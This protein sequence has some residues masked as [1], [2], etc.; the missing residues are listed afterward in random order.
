MSAVATTAELIAV[1]AATTGDHPA[2]TFEGRTVTYA[3]LDRRSNQLLA[4][5]RDAGCQ[6]GDHVAL[7]MENHPHMAEVCWAAYRGG[8]HRT[9]ISP[10][11]LGQHAPRLD[12]LIK[13]AGALG[14][15]PCELIPDLRWTPPARGPAGGNFRQA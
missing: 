12:T 5:L 13:L 11:E 15:E 4:L 6:P 3:E 1:R 10:L 14:V 8:L 2:V 7:V 9:V